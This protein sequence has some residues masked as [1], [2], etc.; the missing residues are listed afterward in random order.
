MAKY[1]PPELVPLLDNPELVIPGVIA[2]QTI[3]N[4]QQTYEALNPQAPLVAN[5]YRHPQPFLRGSQVESKRL[6]H[7]SNPISERNI[8][9]APALAPNA[10]IDAWIRRVE[11]EK[12]Y[13]KIE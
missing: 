6:P 9:N 10:D 5:P 11:D 2:A 12:Q 4:T 7:P 3:R 1:P 8:S 13:S